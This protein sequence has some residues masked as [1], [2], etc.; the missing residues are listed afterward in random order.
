MDANSSAIAAIE[1]VIKG[2][3]DGIEAVETGTV[4]L[5]EAEVASLLP[6]DACE[7]LLQANKK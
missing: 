7:L 4:A 2:A 1:G 3:E 6:G 5:E